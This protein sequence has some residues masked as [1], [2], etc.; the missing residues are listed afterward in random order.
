MLSFKD[1][2]GHHSDCPLFGG[3]EREVS[4]ALRLAVPFASGK[5]LQFDCNT[6]WG[7]FGISLTP[8]VKLRALVVDRKQ[9]PAFA[10]MD[11]LEVQL[12]QA[13][14]SNP[15]S[16]ESDFLVFCQSV[17]LELRPL[18]QRK[19]YLAHEQDKIGLTILWVR[20]RPN[21]MPGLGELMIEKEFFAIIL[22]L[23]SVYNDLPELGFTPAVIQCVTQVLKMMVVDHGADPNAII[24]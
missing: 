7:T 10:C 16:A 5:Y 19:P 13:L 24:Q 6:S 23:T 17:L 18:L 22:E 1:K 9:S 15:R 3:S 14:D 8:G 2:K 4:V 11:R 21:T 20:K 12:F